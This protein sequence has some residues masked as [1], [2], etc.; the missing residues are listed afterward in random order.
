MPDEIRERFELADPNWQ[1]SD[2]AKSRIE[3]AIQTASESESP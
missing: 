2:E 3:A 1:L